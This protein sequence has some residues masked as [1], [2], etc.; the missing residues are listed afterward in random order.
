[1][2]DAPRYTVKVLQIDL[3]RLGIERGAL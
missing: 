2:I 1:M 3:E